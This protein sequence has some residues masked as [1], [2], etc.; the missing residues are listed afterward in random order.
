M[1]TDA[2]MRITMSGLVIWRSRMRSCVA[3]VDVSMVFG[4]NAARRLVASIVVSPWCRSVSKCE[5]VS[6]GERDQ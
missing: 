6:S 5:A 1:T 3:R 4:P 2:R